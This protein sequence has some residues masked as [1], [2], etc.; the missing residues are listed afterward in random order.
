MLEIK[1]LWKDIRYAWETGGMAA[2]LEK[3]G[4]KILGY[5]GQGVEFPAGYEDVYGAVSDEAS[6][7]LWVP[8]SLFGLDNSSTAHIVGRIEDRF[9][10][11]FH[12]KD[13]PVFTAPKVMLSDVIE[14]DYSWKKAREK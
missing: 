14:S 11:S 9:I 3:N 12:K 6:D 13:Q 2:T 1:R 4:A 8:G 7:A 5:A 10:L